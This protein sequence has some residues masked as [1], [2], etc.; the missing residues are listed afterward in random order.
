MSM[1]I[2]MTS[3]S[4]RMS[5]RTHKATTE[6]LAFAMWGAEG[7]PKPTCKQ[8]TEY[9]TLMRQAKEFRELASRGMHPRSYIKQA[10]MHEKAAEAIPKNER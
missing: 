10:E 9:E 1:T 7:M 4:G 6:R 8:P 2:E 5:K 3:P